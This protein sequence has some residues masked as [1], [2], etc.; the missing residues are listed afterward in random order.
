MIYLDVRFFP[1]R[2]DDPERTSDTL[3]FE[4]YMFDK[5]NN[6]SNH[7]TTEEIYIVP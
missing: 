7:V 5:D 2:E 3:K 4:I 6:E 1:L